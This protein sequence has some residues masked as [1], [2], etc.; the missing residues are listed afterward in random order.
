MSSASDEAITTLLV[1]NLHCSRYVNAYVSPQT[2]CSTLFSCVKTIQDALGSLSTSPT[3]VDVSIVTQTVTV[4]HLITLSPSEIKATLDEVGF[5]IV[6][7]PTA[8]HHPPPLPTSI[9]R[10]PPHIARKRLK[11]IQQCPQ[12][13]Q[14]HSHATV[15]DDGRDKLGEDTLVPQPHVAESSDKEK[16]ETSLEG[17]T[18]I[19]SA[20]TPV[21][22]TVAL[23]SGPLHV[24]LSVGGMTCASC[25]NTLTEILT[26][27]PGVSE[28]SVHLLSSAANVSV[29]KEERVQEVIGAIEGAGYDAE[30]VSVNAAPSPGHGSEVSRTSPEGPYQLTLSVGGM[31]CV[32]CTN[33]VTSVTSA[34]PGVSEVVVNLIGKSATAI[35]THKELAEQVVQVIEDAGF[36]AEVVELQSIHGD[37]VQRVGLRTITLQVEG[38]FCP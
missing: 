21:F 26:G 25:S 31:T 1:A 29:D 18:D 23:P 30:V 7:T 16:L 5:D 10:L 3:A 19:S 4:H 14:E 33:T 28:V 24:T 2:A 22:P 34:I 32:S 20:S 6:D 27:L 9:S 8:D 37:Q 13:Q 12:C 15:A 35:L 38:M 11:H 17:R 36:E